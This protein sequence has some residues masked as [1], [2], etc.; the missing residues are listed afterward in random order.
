MCRSWSESSVDIAAKSPGTDSSG[1]SGEL[2]AESPSQSTES[3]TRMFPRFSSPSVLLFAGLL[4]TVSDKWSCVLLSV[5]GSVISV[6]SVLAFSASVRERVIKVSRQ[7]STCGKGNCLGFPFLKFS[8]S[9]LI[10]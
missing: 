3:L 10:I 9:K 5:L 4:S 7:V 8:L 6:G 2:A 1:S